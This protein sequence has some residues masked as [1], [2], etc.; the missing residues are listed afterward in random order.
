MIGARQSK[1]GPTS[2]PPW[3]SIASAAAGGSK[4]GP[5]DGGAGGMGLLPMSDGL[6]PTHGQDARATADTQTPPT[7]GRCTPGNL[8]PWPGAA[9][10]YAS[11]YLIRIM[12]AKKW[13]PNPATPRIIVRGIHLGL[14]EALKSS[15]VEK[16]SRLFRHQERIV[17]LRFDLEH[18][19]TS[20]PAQ[21]FIAKGHIEIH[22]PN[23]VASVSSDDLQKSLDG[24]IDKL[25][26]ML[27]KRASAAKAK[28]RHPHAVE[29]P[30]DLPKAD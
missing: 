1:N 2:M 12:A 23:L 19:Q 28:R 14:R 11:S 16:A 22:G 4:L 21:A 26:G 17:R 30:T 13:K 9:R 27:R 6:T 29:L 20:D 7:I 8:L 10:G 3:P 15:A 18:D 25:D 5:I 24:V